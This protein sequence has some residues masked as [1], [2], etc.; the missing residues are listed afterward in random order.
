M[1]KDS[2]GIGGGFAKNEERNEGGSEEL[3]EHGETHAHKQVDSGSFAH[4]GDLTGPT[5]PHGELDKENPYLHDGGIELQDEILIN[6][7]HETHARDLYT[8]RGAISQEG[9]YN[10]KRVISIEIGRAS[11]RERVCL[12]V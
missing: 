12:Y 11:C 3:E 10:S 2:R 1:F 5:Q 7:A 4:T 6:L 9:L 8:Q